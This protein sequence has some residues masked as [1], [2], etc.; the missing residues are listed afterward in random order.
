MNKNGG[1][2]AENRCAGGSKANKGEGRMS[3]IY[4]N[5]FYK[6]DSTEP[7]VRQTVDKVTRHWRNVA[8]DLGYDPERNVQVEEGEKLFVVAIS[9]ELDSTMR[10]E[11]GDWW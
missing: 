5:R 9:E 10:T 8:L 4:V 2:R 3:W 7:E 6:T 1:A 11:P